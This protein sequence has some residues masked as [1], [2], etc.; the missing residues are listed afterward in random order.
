MI[1]ALLLDYL[2]EISIILLDELT[3]LRGI[4]IGLNVFIFRFPFLQQETSFF[5]SNLE[6]YD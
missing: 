5:E 2:K 6:T 3:I 4:G 1:F